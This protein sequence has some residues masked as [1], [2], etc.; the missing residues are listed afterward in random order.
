MKSLVIFMSAKTELWQPLL[1][2]ID[3]VSVHVPA[4]DE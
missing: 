1:F 3:Q 4:I 2:D